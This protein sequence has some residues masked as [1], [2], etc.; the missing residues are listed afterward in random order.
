MAF[1]PTTTHPNPAIAA[2][3]ALFAISIPLRRALASLAGAFLVV[4]LAVTTSATAQETAPVPPL[5][6]P[7]P[8]DSFSQAPAP[9][10]AP[11]VPPAPQ[12]EDAPEPS[13]DFLLN[14]PTMTPL[15]RDALPYAPAATPQTGKP[16]DPS[17]TTLYMMARLTDNGPLIDNGLVWRVYS[18]TINDEGH[19]DLIAKSKGGDAEFQLDPG[20]YLVYTAYG[21]AGVT[22]KV[23]VARGQTSKT[24]VF[25][26][27]GIKLNGVVSKTVPLDIAKVR[28]DIY[29][30]DFNTRGE[31]KLVARNV[32]PGKIVPL[33]A[34]TYH[35]VSRYGRVNATV[36]ADIK[37][38]AGKLT[39]ATIYHNAAEVTLKLVNEFGGEA[40]ANTAWSVL[41]A[42]GDSV[43]EGNGAF[44]SYVLTAGKYTVVARNQG[45]LFSREFEVKPGRNAE[46][47]VR[48]KDGNAAGL[49]LDTD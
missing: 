23:T 45:R 10:G 48:T 5:P 35:V 37:V 8:E 21:H 38:E 40:I 32:L 34:G 42:S 24:V 14:S 17:E 49:A 6:I 7:S 19:L 33:N 13:L 25:N 3:S 12:P 26:A 29:E 39:E 31:R 9:A 43:V 28:F 30:M 44:P 20:T 41:T 1:R 18:Q 16:G 4:A 36:R 47:E 2:R 27:G 15:P 22:T 11:G 46:V